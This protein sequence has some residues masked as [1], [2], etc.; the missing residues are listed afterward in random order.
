MI[1][2]P[3]QL[4]RSLFRLTHR[5][6][7]QS[8]LGGLHAHEPPMHENVGSHALLHAPQCSGLAVMSTQKPSHNSS[9]PGQL[10]RPLTQGTP[11]GHTMPQPP[12]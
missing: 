10:Q 3:P 8:A 5:P 2:Q 4:L 6:P 1:P 7:P 11:S 12:Q 9:E